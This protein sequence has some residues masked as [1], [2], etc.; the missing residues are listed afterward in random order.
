MLIGS[1][2]CSFPSNSQPF[3]NVAEREF[4]ASDSAQL[5]ARDVQQLEGQCAGL[6]SSGAGVLFSPVMRQRCPAQPIKLSPQSDSVYDW[7]SALL[8]VH[9]PLGPG[10]TPTASTACCCPTAGG[11]SCRTRWLTAT[12]GTSPTS[13]K[14][15]FISVTSRSDG[16]MEFGNRILRTKLQNDVEF[17]RLIL[18]RF[19]GHLNFVVS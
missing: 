4:R 8:R 2:R 18:R 1:W 5:A 17:C 3:P 9:S 7:I 6:C 15:H 16:P 13:G 12:L 10:T 14:Y 11:R 19:Y